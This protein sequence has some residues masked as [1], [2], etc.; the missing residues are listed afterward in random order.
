VS[1]GPG[2]DLGRPRDAGELLRHA[3]RVFLSHPG[4]LLAVS[5]AIVIPVQ[6]IVSGVGLEYLTA[7][8]RGGGRTVEMAISTGVSFLVIA[9]LVTAGTIHVLRS[10]AAG[11]A[12]SAGASIVTAL[13]A[14]TPLLLAVLLSAAGILLGLPLILPAVY[15]AVRWVFVPQTVM[16]DG[17][18]G[19]EALRRSWR[20]VEGFWWRSFAVVLLANL[21]AALP[22]LLVLVPFE[23]LAESADREAVSLVGTMLIDTIT[24]PYVALVVTLLFH[25]LRARRDAGVA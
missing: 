14:F 10:V 8:Y 22:G 17:A 12:P 15:L 16:I 9:P 3:L 23:A 2:L 5:A 7:P 20:L 18:R 24:V 25:D 6:L 19:A 11:E 4:P 21:A 13:E 1:N